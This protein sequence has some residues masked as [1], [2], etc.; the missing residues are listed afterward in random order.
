MFIV[1]TGCKQ[2]EEMGIL[3]DNEMKTVTID[4]TNCKYAQDLFEE[5]IKAMDFPDWCGRNLDA[6]WDMLRGEDSTSVQFIGIKSLPKDLQQ[7]ALRIF[8][9]FVKAEKDEG[10]VHPVSD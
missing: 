3:E 4:F 1:L 2:T 5:T 6:I 8:E 7:E 9:I 10:L